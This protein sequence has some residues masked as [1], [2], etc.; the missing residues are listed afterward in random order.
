MKSYCLTEGLFPQSDLDLFADIKILIEAIP[1]DLTLPSGDV[2]TCHLLVA[3]FRCLFKKVK[4]ETGYFVTSY[5][6]SWF[7]TPSGNVIDLYPVASGYGPW[8]LAG[9]R[10]SPWSRRMMYE[11]G[12]SLRKYEKWKSLDY[13]YF[14]LL[15]LSITKRLVRERA[16][17][18]ANL[19]FKFKEAKYKRRQ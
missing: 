1:D 6:H 2:L 12:H 9:D 5:R 13:Q 16:I 17:K 8:L 7:K 19:R 3:V 14:W 4:P 10:M 11:G 15:M 18:T